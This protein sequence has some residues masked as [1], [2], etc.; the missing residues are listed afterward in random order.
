[1]HLLGV[2]GAGEPVMPWTMRRCSC[3]RGCS[4][5]TSFRRPR[6]DLL[7]AVGHVVGGMTLRPLSASIFLPSSTLVPSR[8]TTSGTLRPTSLTAAITPLAMTSHF[9]MPPKMLTKIALHGFG[10][11]GMILK[12]A[13]TFSWWRRRRRRGSWPAR[14]RSA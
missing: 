4:S 13:V 14:R 7:G 3:R 6:H 9:M 12:A 5:F 2:E 1:M 11:A 8:R 10:V